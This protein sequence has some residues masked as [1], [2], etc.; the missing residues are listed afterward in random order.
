MRKRVSNDGI[1]VNAIG[2]SYVVLLGWTIEEAKRAGLR[3]FAIRRTDF[4]EE[5]VY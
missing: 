1:T 3:G 5:E 4:Q 2:G